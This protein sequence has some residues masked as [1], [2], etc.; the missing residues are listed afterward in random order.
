M[1]S[2]G[3]RRSAL[4]ATLEGD[5]PRSQRFIA[6]WLSDGGWLAPAGADARHADEGDGYLT[7]EVFFIEPSAWLRLAA[8]EIVELEDRYRLDIVRVLM[9]DLHARRLRVVTPAP[10]QQ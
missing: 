3:R 2:W 5:E 4:S 1:T 10:V 7:D 6:R 8:G 9:R